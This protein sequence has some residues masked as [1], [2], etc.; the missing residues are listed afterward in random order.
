[1]TLK[2]SL[3]KCFNGWL[4]K[5]LASSHAFKVSKPSWWRPLWIVSLLGIIIS[6]LVLFLSGYVPLEM[7]IAG[8]VFAFLCVVVAYYIRVK[9]S[10]TVNRALYTLLGITPLGFFLSVAYAFFI[11]R[12]VTGWVGGWFNIIVTVGLLIT[13]GLIGDWIGKRRNH[14]LPLSL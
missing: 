4:P 12:D 7:M 1:M 5:E 14:Q 11:G 2:Q 8:L 10:I 6:G 3:K 13:G 9:P